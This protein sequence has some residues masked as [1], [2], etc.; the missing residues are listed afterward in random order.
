MTTDQVRLRLEWVKDNKQ[1]I[2][3]AQQDSSDGGDV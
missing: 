1:Q 2:E 3:K